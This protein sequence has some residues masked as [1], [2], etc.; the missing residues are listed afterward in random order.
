MEQMQHSVKPYEHAA[1]RPPLTIDKKSAL[2]RFALAGTML[3][4]SAAHAQQPIAA[5]IRAP[6]PFL[7]ER[8]HAK[9]S[10]PE[11]PYPVIYSIPT[12][13]SASTR[14]PLNNPALLP[15]MQQAAEQMGAENYQARELATD[16][17]TNCLTSLQKDV[18]PFPDAVRK[19]TEKRYK[20]LERYYRMRGA[21]L[22]SEQTAP[23]G[24]IIPIAT[25]DTAVTVL[26]KLQTH[27]M[28]RIV[29]EDQKARELLPTL[30]LDPAQN[31]FAEIL[32][33]IGTQTGTVPY[34]NTEEHF[35]VD[36]RPA[37][38]GEVIL[39]E[40]DFG[41]RPGSLIGVYTPPVIIDEKE[42]KHGSLRIVSDPSSPTVAL[43]SAKNGPDVSK[44]RVTL[45]L[46]NN[47]MWSGVDGIRPPYISNKRMSYVFG[48]D[49][50]DT[51][52]IGIQIGVLVAPYSVDFPV[53]NKNKQT[54]GQFDMWLTE[55][56]D[57]LIQKLY[58]T[59]KNGNDTP[60]RHW[61]ESFVNAIRTELRNQ[62]NIAIP[63]SMENLTYDYGNTNLYCM[64]IHSTEPVTTIRV[65]GFRYMTHPMQTKVPLRQFSIPESQ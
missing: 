23:L 55:T 62:R 24:T 25:E 48:S 53:G 45:D 15:Q 59:Y 7:P 36:M 5:P 60:Y 3:I 56:N 10:P 29:I 65:H 2:F 1:T 63:G 17:M 49:E 32:R 31:S 50:P 40:D 6:V 54:V 61:E 22:R 41:K 35:R 28:A 37:R 13:H 42:V 9:P 47:P 34:V 57:P 14:L 39:I 12:I 21:C 58:M 52:K 4:Q 38:N 46:Y 51:R 27:S 16:I 20:N 18:Y 44:L 33:A 19:I 26:E 11:M 64:E 30:Q 8:Q 43:I